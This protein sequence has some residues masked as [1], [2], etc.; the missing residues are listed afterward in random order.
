MTKN[1]ISI[2]QVNSL[3]HNSECSKVRKNANLR[4]KAKSLKDQIINFE[5]HNIERL[6]S[7][8]RILS[9]FENLKNEVETIL[10]LNKKVLK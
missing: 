1:R 5:S 6:E 8:K 10:K 4:V 3:V 9:A 7:P 2:N